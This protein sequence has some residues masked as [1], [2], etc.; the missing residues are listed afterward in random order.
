MEFI[1]LSILFV[2]FLSAGV[3]SFWP[4]FSISVNSLHTN[5]VP[6]KDKRISRLMFERE[7]LYKNILEV[8]FDRAMKKLSNE[9][10]SKL[11]NPLNQKAL[12]VLRRL[13]ALGVKE[14]DVAFGENQVNKN[15]NIENDVRSEIE[16]EIL[17]YRNNNKISAQENAIQENLSDKEITSVETTFYCTTCGNSFGTE[18]KFCSNCGSKI[19]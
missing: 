10:Y 18:D 13:E 2:F 14:G 15:S 8:R 7:N 3:F 16:E 11:L 17:R 1:S 4:L 5:E 6:E 19:K 12:N 9:D